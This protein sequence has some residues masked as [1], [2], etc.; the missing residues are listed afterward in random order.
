MASRLIRL[1]L[2]VTLVAGCA[3]QPATKVT[4]ADR[5]PFNDVDVMFLQMATE[6]IA[7]GDQ[8]AELAAQRAGD[9]E[10]KAVAAELRT[11]WHD[12]DGTMRR[13]LLGWQQPLTAD[14]SAGAHAGHGELHMLRPSD[15]GEL[16][17][18]TAKAFDRTAVS[19]LLGH[20]GNC[21]ETSRMEQAQGAYPPARTL[22]ATVTTR[23]QAQIRRLLK[24]A[25]A[26]G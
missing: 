17:S 8:V 26:G 14:P 1:A 25:A 16:R 22:A 2:L 11:Q 5:Q 24:I 6:Q 7:E 19:L 21:V 23:R 18:A 4:A 15:I 20:L 3:A 10:L 12:E 13:W 9:A